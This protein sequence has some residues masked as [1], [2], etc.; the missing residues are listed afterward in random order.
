MMEMD[1]GMQHKPVP[2]PRTSL[3]NNKSRESSSETEPAE[4]FFEEVIFPAA[5]NSL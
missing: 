1:H 2:K 4:F 3:L 5:T